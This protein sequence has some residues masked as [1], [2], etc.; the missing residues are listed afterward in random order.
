MDSE[1][2][3]KGDNGEEERWPVADKEGFYQSY[4][5]RNSGE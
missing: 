5:V 2:V 1:K 3:T 4:K